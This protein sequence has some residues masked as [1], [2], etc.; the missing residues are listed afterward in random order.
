MVGR[1]VHH[2][3]ATV[4]Q[5]G[6]E[7]CGLRMRVGDCGKITR[8]HGLRFV[9]RQ[10]ARHPILRRD[11]DQPASGIRPRGDLPEFEMRMRFDQRCELRA[12]ETG[13]ADH[14]DSDH[15]RNSASK[16]PWSALTTATT[17]ASISSSVNVRPGSAIVR[18]SAKLTFPAGTGSPT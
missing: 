16:L 17:G 14:M 8:S 12:R 1:D 7:R 4:D 11:I 10:L 15:P 3:H 13:G 18:R 9:D 5:R 2:A 6:D